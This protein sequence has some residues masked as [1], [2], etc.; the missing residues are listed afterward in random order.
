MRDSTHLHRVKV[1]DMSPAIII[2][3][4]Q[5][6][7]IG[8]NGDLND[9]DY[10]RLPELFIFMAIMMNPLSHYSVTYAS[11]RPLY[12]TVTD[13]RVSQAVMLEA[14]QDARLF[15]REVDNKDM[16]RHRSRHHQFGGIRGKLE[17]ETSG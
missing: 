5:P 3:C 1:K 7:S 10:G 13:R 4:C 15:A 2:G 6:L 8:T 9:V 14:S 16:R 17:R 11:G 12:D